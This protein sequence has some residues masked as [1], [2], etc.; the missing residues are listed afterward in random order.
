VKKLIAILLM[1]FLLTQ[2]SGDKT[3]PYLTQKEIE[4]LKSYESLEDIH[5]VQISNSKEAGKELWL[6]LEFVSESDKSPLKNQKI[7]LY[8][9][10][11]EGEYDPSDPN[12]ESTARLNGTGFTNVRGQIFVQTILPGDFG[13]SKNNRHIHT[14]V[15]DAGPE[16]YDIFFTQYSGGIGKI[17]N[18]GNDQLFYADLKQTLNGT[19]VAYLTIK[20]KSP[21]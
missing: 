12:D 8:H 9:T 1:S 17:L 11:S 6:C 4:D 7:K 13:E 2:C 5:Q 3:F 19:L 16:A 20:V 14:T 15:F 18:S 21:G 10:S